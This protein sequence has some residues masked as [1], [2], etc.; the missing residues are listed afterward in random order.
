MCDDFTT[1]DTATRLGVSRRDLAAL[2]GTTLAGL[3]M[4]NSALAAGPALAESAVSLRTLDGTM[5]AFFV[6]PATGAHPAVVMW[7]DIAGLRDAY[8]VMARRLA[9]AGYAVLVPNQYYRSAR[10]PVLNT[11]SEWFQPANQARLKPMIAQLD[12]AAVAR[13]AMGLVAWLDGQAAVNRRRG[14]GTAGFCM[15]G[16]FT[17]RMAAAAPARVHAA[18]SFHGGGLVTDKGDSPHRMIGQTRARFLIAIARNDDARAPGEKDVLKAAFAKAQRTAEIEV[19]PADHGWCTLDAPSYD[20]AS[21]EKAWGRMLA[22][23]AQL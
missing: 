11:L 14:I 21:A 22:H 4:A 18:A 13:D 23:F 9:T 12:G 20:K 5:D 8:R 3:A 7:P 17:L 15:T 16:P 2:G 1:A 19:Y 6:H 10:A